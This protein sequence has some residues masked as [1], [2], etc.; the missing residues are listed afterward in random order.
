[1]KYQYDTEPV[2]VPMDSHVYQNGNV[3]DVHY[4]IRDSRRVMVIGKICDPSSV[5][6]ELMARVEEG[7]MFMY[8][9]EHYFETHVQ[10]YLDVFPERHDQ[11][12]KYTLRIGLYTIVLAAS[13]RLGL[14]DLLIEAYGPATANAILDFAM[15]FLLNDPDAD[16]TFHERMGSQ[17]LFSNSLYPD[18]W[19]TRFFP[20]IMQAEQNRHFLDAWFRHVLSK[21]TIRSVSITVDR[22]LRNSASGCNLP[23]NGGTDDP[24]TSTSQA[25][26]MWVGM[27]DGTDPGL[28]L[29]LSFS[30]EQGQAQTDLLRVIDFWKERGV[31]PTLYFSGAELPAEELLQNL[32]DHGVPF[33]ILLDRSNPFFRSLHSNYADLIREKVSCFLSIQGA[34]QVEQFCR[35]IRQAQRNAEKQLAACLEKCENDASGRDDLEQSMDAAEIIPSQF[36]RYLS[37]EQEE[38]KI[39]VVLCEDEIQADCELIGYTA[40]LSSE[41]LSA[42]EMARDIRDPSVMTFAALNETYGS[43]FSDSDSSAGNAETV[44]FNRLVVF[45]VTGILSNEI[46][47]ICEEEGL[48]LQD[49]MKDLNRVTFEQYG[50]QYLFEGKLPDSFCQVCDRLDLIPEAMDLFS[51][52]VNSRYDFSSETREAMRGRVRTVPKDLWKRAPVQ[53]GS[54][55]KAATVPAMPSERTEGVEGESPA[56]ESSEV[57]SVAVVHGTDEKE[58]ANP[59]EEPLPDETAP[60]PAASE[61][62]GRGRPKGSKNRKTLQ[63][64]EEERSRRRAAGLPEE[65][66]PRPKRGRG[67]PK[68]SRNRKTLERER[69][70]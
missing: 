25:E 51:A 41:P 42:A 22:N 36:S 35:E 26:M 15:Y 4:P 57:E 69:L 11:I 59:N 18:S 56:E 23:G 40:Q 68:G 19:Y 29:L 63:R 14:Y 12:R 46:R 47:N 31:R 39:E 65:E 33:Q 60:E 1:M 54:P 8:P 32:K 43:D 45:F 44:L 37:L 38:G 58:Q 16:H 13:T 6:P 34:Q 10:D 5:P 53:A 61:K 50:D 48:S 28:P 52:Y 7:T 20:E 64:E 70:Q 67:R 24:A 27:K 49:L 55:P 21:E 62:R 17:V 3:V 30:P 2:P 66:P 9:N